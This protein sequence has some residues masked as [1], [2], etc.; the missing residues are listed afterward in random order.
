MHTCLSHTDM[1]SK[2]GLWY[3]GGHYLGQKVHETE[4]QFTRGR[5]YEQGTQLYY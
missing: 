4:T 2:V 3:F 1:K 5:N